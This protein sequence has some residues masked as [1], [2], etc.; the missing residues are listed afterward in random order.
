MPTTI[1]MT[2]HEPSILGPN[3]H[4]LDGAYGVAVTETGERARQQILD[5]L[6]TGIYALED[7]ACYCGHENKDVVLASVDRYRI[8]HRTVLC[9]RCGLVRTD[10]RMVQ[11]AYTDFYTHYYRDLY[12]R[13]NQQKEALFADQRSNALRRYQFISEHGDLKPSSHI[14][15]IGCG[16]GWNLLPF[17]ENGHHTVGY[18]FNQEYLAI[19]N[20]HGLRL[21]SGGLEEVLVTGQTFDLVIMSHVVEHLHDPIA[22]MRQVALLLHPGGRLYVEVPSVFHV[23][24]NLLKYFQ[25]AHTYSFIPDTL[26]NVM[27]S[28]GFREISVT[29]FIESL[30][31]YDGRAA[32]WAI[33]P[34]SSIEILDHLSRL[35][36]QERYRAVF[37]SFKTQVARFVNVINQQMKHTSLLQRKRYRKVR[38]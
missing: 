38:M 19:G 21:Q 25:S 22:Q 32:T 20:H 37:Y 17:H 4:S 15:E 30:W 3:Y 33:N 6:Q 7:V 23:R 2:F 35:E 34:R 16:A 28:A 8:P 29:P 13:P 5:K 1:D 27:Q 10:P 11:E 31:A 36:K 18:D 12:E 26:R 24:T 9:T 14:L